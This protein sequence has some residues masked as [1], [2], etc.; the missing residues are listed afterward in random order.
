VGIIK[1]GVGMHYSK[2]FAIQF[3]KIKGIY[4]RHLYS[5]K[6]E[7]CSYSYAAIPILASP[8]FGPGH[9]TTCTNHHC[10]PEKQPAKADNTSLA[11]FECKI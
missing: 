2:L 6:T 9:H 1:K 3:I 10:A 4:R 11:C 7:L 5:T 8:P